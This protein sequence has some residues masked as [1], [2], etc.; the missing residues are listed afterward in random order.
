M[1]RPPGSSPRLTQPSAHRIHSALRGRSVRFVAGWLCMNMQAGPLARGMHAARTGSRRHL[2][3]RRRRT[4]PSFV[5][6][7]AIRPR[8]ARRPC[9]SGWS[10]RLTAHQERQDP[11]DVTCKQTTAEGHT[12]RLSAYPRSGKP[13]RS[14]LGCSSRA[15]LLPPVESAEGRSGGEHDGSTHRRRR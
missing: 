12:D 10:A 1:T 5:H 9:G 14:S 7:L 15:G 3:G 11:G 13:S 2:E 6:G 4:Y 8:H